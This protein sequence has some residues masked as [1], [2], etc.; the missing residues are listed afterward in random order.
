MFEF[1][2]KLQETR[3]FRNSLFMLDGVFKRCK[4]RPARVSFFEFFPGSDPTPNSNPD[5]LTQ[6]QIGHDLGG[7]KGA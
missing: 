6:G 3:G 5:P 2:K 4:P 7:P 1:L